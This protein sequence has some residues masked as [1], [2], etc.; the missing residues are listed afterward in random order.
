LKIGE[1]KVCIALSFFWQNILEKSSR[2][3]AMKFAMKIMKN[4]LNIL[5]I[6]AIGVSLVLGCGISERIQKSISGDSKTTKSSNSKTTSPDES[7]ADK[8]IDSVADGETTGVPECDEVI[9]IFEDQS[10]SNDDNWMVKATRD[11]AVG[12]IKKSFRES[13]EKNKDDKTKMA[14][15]CKDYKSKLEKALAEEKAKPKE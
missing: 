10:K 4:K 13:I 2:Y 1:G 11:Y 9:K 6:L 15:N 12:I 14:A 3:G 5:V 7:L 8:A